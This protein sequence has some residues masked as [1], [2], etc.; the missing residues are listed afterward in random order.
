MSDKFSQV[1]PSLKFDVLGDVVD[2]AL[3]AIGKVS[4]EAKQRYLT[5]IEETVDQAVLDNVDAAVVALL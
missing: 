4:G 3:D 1:A 2:A 5:Y